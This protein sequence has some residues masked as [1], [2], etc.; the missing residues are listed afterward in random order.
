MR[1]TR[2]DL[3]WAAAA[4]PTVAPGRVSVPIH[5]I[6]DAKAQ[7][8]PGSL[9][10]FWSTIW[11][12]AVTDFGRGGIDLQTTDGPGEVAHSAA[13]RPIFTGLR[14]GV[15]NFVITDRL[16]LY[17]D[18]GRSLPGVTTLDRG[19]HL[20]MIAIRYAHAN[21]IPFFSLNTCVHEI[22]HGLFLDILV[23]HPSP[24]QAVER[25]YRVDWYATRLWIFH[26]GAAIRQSARAYLDRLRA[27]NA[28][29]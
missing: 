1:I 25:E 17:W 26:D 28:M 20:S 29:R 13:D 18:A 4:V 6:V 10:R 23:T 16:P 27:S 11:P 3:I 9:Q 8:P 24:E 15:L 12:E 5:R 14:H 21:R 2:R 19:Y 7:F 22:L